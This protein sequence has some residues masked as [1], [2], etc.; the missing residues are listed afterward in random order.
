[1]RAAEERRSE[2]RTHLTMPLRNSMK[3][4]LQ[5]EESAGARQ[6]EEDVKD[7]PLDGDVEVGNVVEDEADE[8]LVL[9]LAEVLDEA[10][11]LERLAELDRRQAVLSEAVV[12][13]ARDCAR[14][15]E[16]EGQPAG[17]KRDRETRR[18]VDA[19]SWPWIASCSV[20]L[21]RSEPPTK[22][23]TAFWRTCLRTSSM[24]GEAVCGQAAMGQ[25]RAG[26]VKEE[27]GTHAASR[28]KSAV[29]VCRMRRKEGGGGE[30]Q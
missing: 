28:R 17:R 14:G 23:M 9:V 18:E 16:R 1:M 11:A 5:V 3:V 10:L 4:P 27:D 20:I 26:A 24:A 19:L 12:K 13:V 7:A 2:G 29:D 6:D 25:L 30:G 21:A 15:R 22:P 8:L